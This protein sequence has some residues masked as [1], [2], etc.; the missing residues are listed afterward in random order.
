[1]ILCAAAMSMFTISAQ[2]KEET[3]PPPAIN[4]PQSAGAEDVIAYARIK[5]LSE[6]LG[7]LDHWGGQINPNLP[8][9]AVKQAVGQYMGDESLSAIE[10][11]KPILI[12]VLNPKEFP[13]PL[14]MYLP[15]KNAEKIKQGIQAKGS[16]TVVKDDMVIVGDDQPSITK[17]TELWEK[18][19]PLAEKPLSSSVVLSANVDKIMSLY[20]Q[21]IRQKI[22]DM[23]SQMMMMQQMQSGSTDMTKQQEQI[24]A[25]SEEMIK[26]IEGLKDVGIEI[27][28][29]NQK[30]DFSFLGA[31]KTGSDLATLFSTGASPHPAIYKHLPEGAVRIAF[32]A[33]TDTITEFKSKLSDRFL[34]QSGLLDKE[35]KKMVE[36]FQSLQNEALANEMAVSAFVDGVS[37][38]NAVTLYTIKDKE[39][40]MEMIRMTPKQLEM[41]SNEAQGLTITTEYKENAKTVDGVKVHSMKMN[42]N[43]QNPMAAQQMMMFMPQG[44]LNIEAAVVDDVMITATGVPIDDTI[45]AIKNKTGSMNI[46][47]MSQYAKGGQLYGDLSINN[48]LKSLLGPMFTMMSMGSQGP[49]PVE[50]LGNIDAPPLTFFGSMHDNKAMCNASL[51][52][53]TILKIKEVFQ[54]MG[55]GGGAQP[56]GM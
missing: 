25:Q 30:M 35:Q 31:A 39:K 15:V 18:L 17:G 8:P 32:A 47:A 49:N 53:E 9:G 6:F 43:F 50:M 4:I 7:V 16:F 51:S 23:Q 1:M 40:A 34:S 14:V 56:S 3:P 54:Q 55:M 33:D 41:G 24:A 52:L 28:A 38:L 44:G 42:M 20:G 13:N 45:R 12:S 22:K 29:T 21:D 27:N 10:T 37:G 19:K 46:Q 36:K 26:M 5:N 11:G 2:C 48:L